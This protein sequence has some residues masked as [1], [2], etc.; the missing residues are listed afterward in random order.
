MNRITLVIAVIVLAGLMP[1]CNGPADENPPVRISAIELHKAFM[2]DS[3]TAESRLSKKRL[4]ITGEVAIAT[5]RTSGWTMR[6]EVEVPARVY[7]R[8]ELDYLKTDIKYVVCNG[9]F[10]IPQAG[11][12]YILDPRIGMDKPL[13][14]E[15]GSETLRWSS[16]GLYLSNCRIANP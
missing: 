8:T 6:K 16:P 1:A 4:L 2:A 10:D 7:L 12:G 15:C 11:G 3:R 14:V 5:A 13:T 9:D